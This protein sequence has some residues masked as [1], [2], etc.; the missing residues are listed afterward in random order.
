MDSENL[1]QRVAALEADKKTIFRQLA[2]VK[3]DI[4]DI[5]RLT[6]AVERIAVKT[7]II[8][9][10]VDG[11]DRRLGSVESAPAEDYRHFKR[12]VIGGF[13]TTIIA[14]VLSAVISQIIK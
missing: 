2:E 14:S 3:E 5:R 11:I 1:A 7:E 9:E 4:K 8:G 12:V 6:A 10:K 13:V